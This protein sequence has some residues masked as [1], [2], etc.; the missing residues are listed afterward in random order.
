MS[1]QL[2]ICIER[3]II[4]QECIPVG[5]EPSACWPYHAVLWVCVCVCPSILL[6]R[7]HPGQTPTVD[8]ILNIYF[9]KHYFPTTTVADGN[10]T[11]TLQPHPSLLKTSG[12]EHRNSQLLGFYEHISLHENNQ[13]KKGS[14]ITRMHS[15]RMH[16]ICCSGLLSCHAC[17]PCTPPAMHTTLPCMLPC[18]FIINFPSLNFSFLAFF[19]FFTFTF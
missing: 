14:V 4:Q 19:F 10:K 7:H 1:F 5:C 17:P 18:H 8:R 11:S 15:S 13:C 9:W 3:L 16:T 12:P 2:G 6:G